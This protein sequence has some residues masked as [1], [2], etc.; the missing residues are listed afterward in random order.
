MTVQ[1]TDVSV[2]DTTNGISVS[3]PGTF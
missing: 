3:F 1:Y 2:T